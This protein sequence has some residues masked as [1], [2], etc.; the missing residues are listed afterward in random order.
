MALA[1]DL[2]ADDEEWIE[3][4]LARAC[5]NPLFLEHLLRAGP[6]VGDAV[7]AS[8]PG[9]IERRL[10][11]L[12]ARERQVVQAAP[13]LGQRVSVEALAA[14]VGDPWDGAP[15][16]AL[17]A[18]G[19]VTWEG[20]SVWRFSHALVRDG[21]EQTLTAPAR[22]ALHRRAAD[23]YAGRDAVRQA[24]HLAQA[25]DPQAASALLIAARQALRG[26]RYQEA[27][28]LAVR[29]WRLASGV[30]PA[31]RAEAGLFLGV[32]H[33]ELGEIPA[34]RR[35]LKAVIAEGGAPAVLCD[36]RLELAAAL[37]IQDAYQA[38]LA[39]GEAALVEGSVS[40]NHL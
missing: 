23:W 12:A 30:D 25:G 1:R 31:T 10:A 7:P 38:A 18:A 14:L 34:A 13:V 27:L 26:H 40:H 16:A 29:A 11:R 17:W 24:R 22:R 39:E 33:R 3:R 36:A 4:S 8:V 15:G 6:A 20:G 35:M 19:L 21:I 5:G 32:L 28:G 37:L 9:L 2:G